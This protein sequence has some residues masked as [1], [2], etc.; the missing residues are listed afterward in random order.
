MR[1]KGLGCRIYGGSNQVGLGNP[2]RNIDVRLP[3][4]G[5]SNLHGARL[6]HLIITMMRWFRT[7]RLSSKEC[8]FSFEND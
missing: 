4:Q 5:N 2:T 3:G 7:R 6:V 8:L 1:V